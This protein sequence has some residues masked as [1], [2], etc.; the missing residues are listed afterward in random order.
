MKN[1]NALYLTLAI[2]SLLVG[3][4]DTNNSSKT[5]SSNNYE[6]YYEDVETRA[7][8]DKQNDKNFTQTFENGIDDNLFYSL[9]GAWHTNVQGA[10]HEGMKHRNLFYTNDGKDD[11]L[12]IRALGKY[13]KNKEDPSKIGLPEGGCIVS[14]E[15]L[16]PGRYEIEMAAMPREGGVTAMW[17]YCTTTGNEATSQNE[18]D[19]EIG[20]T[21]DGT[22]FKNMWCTS[23]T[24]QTVKDTD[25]VDVSDSLY[26]NDR[27]IHKY[28]FDW[29]TNYGSEGTR[30]IDWFIDGKLIKQMEGNV[31][32]EHEMPLWVGVWFPPLWAGNASFEEDYMLIKSISY[33]AFDSTSQYFENCRSNPSYNKVNPSTLSIQKI[34]FDKIKNLNQFSNGDMESLDDKSTKDN[35][36]YGWKVDQAS[37]GTVELVDG[38]NSKHG[39]KLIASKDTSSKYHGEYLVQEITNAYE[40]YKYNLSIDAK[41]MTSESNGNIEIRYINAGGKTINTITYSIDSL[42][43]KTYTNVITMPKDSF[44]L[45]ITITSE[46]GEVAYDNAS[47]VFVR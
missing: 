9:E 24:K 12:A 29:Y 7:S 31:V 2:S 23:W 17:T 21:T 16:G 1:K 30:H 42:E 44:K 11:Y 38:N 27:K 20:G 34:D 35:S 15:H 32:P 6:T 26:L 3:C 10:E 36:Y 5:N 37:K 40:G 39:Y 45:E 4:N 18:I 43:Y 25:T 47:L 28:T 8:F 46:D 19:I 41:K 33:Q 13:S 14:K 22:N